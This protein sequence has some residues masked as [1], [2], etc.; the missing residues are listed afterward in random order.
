[1]KRIPELSF[2]L[3]LAAAMLTG[4]SSGD[5]NLV[6]D[7]SS[8]EQSELVSDK[9]SEE[10]SSSDVE[11]TSEAE[12]TSD[13]ESSS[14]A[15]SFDTA[16]NPEYLEND[17]G[18]LKYNSGNFEIYDKYFRALWI[19]DDDFGDR[20][21][22][23]SGSYGKLISQRPLGYS[24]LGSYVCMHFIQGGAGNIYMID[25]NDPDVMYYYEDLGVEPVAVSD[26]T[27]IYKK[28]STEEDGT[29]GY[30]GI[31]KLNFVDNIPSEF[32]SGAV[33]ST[34]D[35]QDWIVM[36]KMTVAEQ[37]DDHIIL[38]AECCK[39]GLHPFD[40]GYDEVIEPVMITYTIDWSGTICEVKDVH[41]TE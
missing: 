29:L 19:S 12:S 23:Y 22:R 35:G 40:V 6:S 13:D 30:F 31:Q 5:I 2:S 4:C 8:E 25:R 37:A 15:E 21:F 39:D 17:G 7:I 34:D 28:D 32:L 3:L 26:Y 10:E 1:M 9:T 16:E 18:N 11:S 33:I 38:N 41:Y 27:R 20:D 36:E 24:V 14:G